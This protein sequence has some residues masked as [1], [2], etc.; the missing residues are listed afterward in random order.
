MRRIPVQSRVL[1]TRRDFLGGC[2]ATIAAAALPRAALAAVPDAVAALLTRPIPSTGERLPVIGLGTNAY[3]VTDPADL[4]SR[5]AV[6]ARLL[7]L[8]GKVIDTARAYGDSELVI[9]RILADLK[10]RDRVFLATKTPIDGPLA[11]PAAIVAET[12]RRLGTETVDLLQIHNMHG[13]EELMPTLRKLK[14]ER[15]VRYLGATTSRDEQYPALLAAMRAHPL[16]FVQVDYSIANRNAAAE[17]LPLAAD[18]GIA[19]LVNMPFG[20][21]RDGN[22]LRKLGE[23]QRPDREQQ[24]DRHR[25]DEY[26]QRQAQPPVVAEA[27]SARAEDQRVV[28]VADRRQEGAGRADRHRHQERIGADAELRRAVPMPIGHIT[29]AVAALFIRSDSVIVTTRI[30]ASASTACPWATPR[31]GA[32]RS[33]RPCRWCHGAGDRDQRAEQ[34]DHRPVDRLVDRR[35]GIVRSAIEAST[36]AANEIAAGTRPKAAPPT[37]SPMMTSA[38]IACAVGDAQR[39]FGQRHA[40]HARRKIGDR[41]GGPCIS[42]TSPAASGIERSRGRTRPWR[43]TAS[44]LMP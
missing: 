28:L 30:V 14:E 36:P 40:V 34:H 32:A 43:E 19:V 24:R 11:D 35:G 33:G 38:V 29:A 13:V 42:S 23:L 15:R 12:F 16:D 5:Q 27:E 26:L 21:R 6:V 25:D 10:A 8:G 3:S 44:R 7:E 31:S 1:P 37:A 39:A 22:L 4:A 2:A 41:I 9:G 17:V 20:G 18:R